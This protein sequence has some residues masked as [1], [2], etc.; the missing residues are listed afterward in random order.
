M[1]LPVDWAGD[2]RDRDLGTPFPPMTVNFPI[3]L[4]P[5]SIIGLSFYSQSVWLDPLQNA[6]GALTS[7]AIELRVGVF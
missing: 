5:P 3:P 7:N 2:G 6:F 1:E 4:G